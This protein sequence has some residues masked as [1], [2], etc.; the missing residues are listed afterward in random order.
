M[1][2]DTAKFA[3]NVIPSKYGASADDIHTNAF[4][5]LKLLMEGRAVCHDF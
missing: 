1:L 4:D 3:I 2:C 5:L